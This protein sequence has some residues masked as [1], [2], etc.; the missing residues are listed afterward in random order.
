MFCINCSH[1]STNV[2][3]SRPSKKLPSVWR[4]RRCPKCLYVFST[5]ERPRYID[6]IVTDSRDEA[7]APFN[8]GTLTVSIANSFQHNL[9]R[10][11]ESAWDLMETITARLFGVTAEPVTTD[12]IARLT[13]DTLRSY[14]QVAGAQYALTHHM[15]TTSKKRGRPS[16][17]DVAAS[18]GHETPR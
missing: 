4:R 6:I 3:N 13:Y 15:I 2:T 14:D 5:D 9:F 17:G 11:R 12:L 16:L 1:S 10:G 7:K 18:R 8:P